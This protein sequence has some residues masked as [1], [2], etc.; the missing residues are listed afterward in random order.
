MEI[1]ELMKCSWSMDGVHWMNRYI[2][3][4]NGEHVMNC[5]WMDGIGYRLGTYWVN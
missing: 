5:N 2:Y 1:I 3:L 4:A